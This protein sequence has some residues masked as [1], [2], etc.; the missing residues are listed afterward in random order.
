MPD[1]PEIYLF[2][3][4]LYCLLCAGLQAFSNLAELWLDQRRKQAHLA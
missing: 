2:T 4:I 3:A 1:Q